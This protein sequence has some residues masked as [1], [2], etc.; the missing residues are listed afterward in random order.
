ML[1]HHLPVGYHLRSLSGEIPVTRNGSRISPISFT[2][3]SFHLIEQPVLLSLPNRSLQRKLLV[4]RANQNPSGDTSC[5]MSTRLSEVNNR[6]SVHWGVD[7]SPSQDA[8]G[9]FNPLTSDLS[10]EPSF[11]SSKE[12]RLNFRLVK[13]FPSYPVVT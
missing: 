13:S 4:K 5:A 8:D 12:Q 9:N 6:W 7:S 2:S 1:E 3:E 11:F 10:L